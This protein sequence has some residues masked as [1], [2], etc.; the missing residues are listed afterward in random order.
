MIGRGARPSAT[1]H[2]RRTA[3]LVHHLT[4]RAVQ[5]RAPVAPRVAMITSAAS[6]AA[7]RQICSARW[8]W[9][10]IDAAQG[11]VLATWTLGRVIYS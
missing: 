6:A 10:I 7:W 2:K 3:G 1:H 5:R 9:R 8:P 11:D 4:D